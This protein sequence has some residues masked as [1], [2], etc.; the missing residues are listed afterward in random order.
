VTLEAEIV[1]LT[2]NIL[3]WLH[4]HGPEYAQH[5]P[6]P[7]ATEAELAALEA[8]LGRPLPPALAALLRVANGDFYVGE[9]TALSTQAIA[10]TWGIG[11]QLLADGTYA[12]FEP[13]HDSGGILQPGWWHPGLIPVFEDSGGNQLC[14]DLDP[15]PRGIVGQMV[16]WEIHEGPIPHGADS[17]LT[18]LRN[19]WEHLAS[20]K[21]NSPEAWESAGCWE[22]TQVKQN[23]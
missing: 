15:G 10:Y 20:G 23:R 13:H 7:G 19:H 5:S 9:Y 6:N 8:T 11:R 14:I 12:R 22:L 4:E 16:W 17:L 2:T 18:L 21:Y 1:T 3:A